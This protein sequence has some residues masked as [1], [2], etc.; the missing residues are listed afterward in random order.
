MI[1]KYVDQDTVVKQDHDKTQKAIAASRLK[2]NAEYN[3]AHPK[4][5]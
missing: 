5:K 4:Q 1:D 3:R 2:R